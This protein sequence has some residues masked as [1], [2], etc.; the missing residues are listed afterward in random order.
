MDN[1]FNNSLRLENNPST[2]GS[3]TSTDLST[4]NE[5]QIRN[6]SPNLDVSEND[7]E[8]TINCELPGIDKN[9]VK[10]D[11]HNG[12]L[13]ITGERKHE[14]KEENEKYHRIERSYGKFSRSL[15]LP[16]GCDPSKICACFNNGVLKVTAPKGEQAKPHQISI[17]G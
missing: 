14:K 11:C 7:K 8:I 13:T 4:W 5:P 17:A 1:M 9:D 16:E 15:R 10:I 3:S 2:Q 12:L 6:W